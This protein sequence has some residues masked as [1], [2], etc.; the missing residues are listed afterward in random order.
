MNLKK[1]IA[2]LFLLCSQI[3]FSQNLIQNGSFEDAIGNK[4][5][6]GWF[7]NCG[8]LTYICNAMDDSVPFS[9][10]SGMPVQDA[11]PNGGIWSLHCPSQWPLVGGAETYITN[12][13]DTAYYLLSAWMKGDGMSGGMM[14]LQIK[15]QG[16][17]D[18]ILSII[19]DTSNTWQFYDTIIELGLQETDTIIIQI[20][21]FGSQTAANHLF[22][23]LVQL[24]RLD[25][26]INIYEPEKIKN[27][28]IF[29]LPNPFFNNLNIYFTD[30]LNNTQ[31]KIFNSIGQLLYEKKLNNINSKYLIINTSNWSNG[32][33]YLIVKNNNSEFFTKKMVKF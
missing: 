11:P 29:I 24:I 16:Q 27:D 8:E 3:C 5:C 30:P 23:D 4:R 19:T 10:C 13:N 21:A 14:I 31:I 32:M 1:Y 15:S 17:I 20:G 9:L 18:Y 25:S 33:Y 7:D 26:I 28:K 2:I 22:V 6:D 12:Q